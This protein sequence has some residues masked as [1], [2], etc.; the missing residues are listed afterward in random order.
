MNFSHF[1]LCIPKIR[2]GKNEREGQARRK[3]WEGRKI[4][5]GR[6]GTT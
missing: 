5:K 6:L 4:G 3:E 1:Y 2:E